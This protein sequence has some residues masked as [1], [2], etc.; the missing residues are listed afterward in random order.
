MYFFQLESWKVE[1][2]FEPRP[3]IVYCEGTLKYFRKIEIS[4][5]CNFCIGGLNVSED[6]EVVGKGGERF[7]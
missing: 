6:G 2:S 3:V 1:R 7:N 5:E 4:R